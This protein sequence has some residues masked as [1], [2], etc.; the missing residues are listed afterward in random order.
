MLLFRCNFVLSNTSGWKSPPVWRVFSCRDLLLHCVCMIHTLACTHMCM[1]TRGVTCHWSWITPLM[2]QRV[3]TPD[4]TGSI[5][6]AQL[7]EH[8]SGALL[9]LTDPHGTLNSL[10]EVFELMTH[11]HQ[12]KWQMQTGCSSAA[13]KLALFL[14]SC[15]QPESCFTVVLLIGISESHS[16]LSSGSSNKLH[17]I[18]KQRKGSSLSNNWQKMLLIHFEAFENDCCWNNPMGVFSHSA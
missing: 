13:H 9:A 2:S 16:I 11:K 1:H 18:N 17:Y 5:C 15:Q 12:W 6:M 4:I 10:I 8:E 3:H 14:L 7:V